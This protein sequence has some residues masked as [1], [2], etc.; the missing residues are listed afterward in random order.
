M[1]CRSCGQPLHHVVVDLG[2][3][4]PA[5]RYLSENQ[6]ADPR[7]EPRFGLR[8]LV[9]EACW[10]VQLADSNRSED[11]F[12]PDYAY[13]SSYVQSWVDHASRY[14]DMAVS[15]FG[16][17]P[18]SFVIEAASNDGY[19]LQHFVR[20]G[21]PCLGIDPAAQ[22]AAAAEEKGVPTVI[23]FFGRDT[24][25][26]L[27]A[28]RGAADLILG[29]NVLAHVPNVN[30]FVDG[31]ATLLAPD[32]AATM[33]FPHLGRLLAETQFDTIYDEHFSY[34]SFGAVRDIFARHGLTLFDVD[35]LPTH[36]GSLRIFAQH[37]E[38]GP[39]AISPAVEN[40]IAEETSQG[41]FELDTYRGFGDRVARI[42]DA[43]RTYVAEQKENGLTI[44]AF[45]AAAKGNTFLNTC[46]I[47]HETIDFVVDDTPLKQGRYLPGSHVPVVT[48]QRLR[49]SKPDII[50]I[51]PWNVK[52]EIRRKLAYTREWNAKLVTFIPEREIA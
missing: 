18:H 43:F 52:A 4:P 29:N 15:R 51:L 13:F 14:V 36:G 46:G 42:C 49:E 24:A 33:E 2:E 22:A 10:L 26:R 45:G 41:L 50:L 44:A 32:G 39:H 28:E 6:L 48:E 9:C 21:V 34:Y 40:L 25:D 38:S 11:M 8:V 30:D 17:G 35:K 12:T 7:N 1:N 19:L 23:D 47:G 20:V 3:Q 31:I 37:A 16:L 5:N 27:C